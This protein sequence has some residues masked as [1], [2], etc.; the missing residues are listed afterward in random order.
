MRSRRVASWSLPFLHE[1]KQL[2]VGRTEDGC[3]FALDNRCP[4]EGYP[5]QAGR[6][7]PEL[8]RREQPAPIEGIL[9]AVASQDAA[10][11]T[12]R[13]SAFLRGGGAD[14]VA[15]LARVED[16]CL[17]DPL[18]RPIVVAH[19]IKTS[20]AAFEEYGALVDHP[21]R[22]WTLLSAVRF[23]ASPVVERRVAETAR[24]SIRWV[25]EGVMPKKLTQ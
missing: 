13:L 11:A 7:A 1:G 17:A 23:L 21:D 12:A 18:V 16:L 3:A 2:V 22:D 15:L 24:R 9:A 25:H 6:T 20:I 19:A 10:S 14:Q 4:H 8:P 5:F